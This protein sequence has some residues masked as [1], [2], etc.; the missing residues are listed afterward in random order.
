MTQG[1]R[2]DAAAVPVYIGRMMLPFPQR[3]P[4][5]CAK[6]GHRAEINAALADLA[7]KMLRCGRC[8]HR[9]PFT[10]ESITR[11]SR[12]RTDRRTRAARAVLAT[13]Q[14]GELDDQVND[15]WAA[16]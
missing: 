7:S 15:L 11:P 16:G 8:G 9:Q 6:C 13:M 3:W 10:P 1:A 2:G 12:P 4:V 5:R 14:P